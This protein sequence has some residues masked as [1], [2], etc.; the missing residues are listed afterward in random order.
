MNI[1]LTFRLGRNTLPTEAEQLHDLWRVARLLQ[2][3]GF[4]ISRWYPPAD[5]PEHSLLNPA[6]DDNGPTPAAVAIL[7]AEMQALQTPWR[8]DTAV[9]NGTEGPGGVVCV[10]AL[11]V[12]PYLPNCTL[13]LNAKRV[14]ALQD[15]RNVVTVVQGLLQIWQARTLEVAP[16]RYQ[17]RMKVFPDRP[18]AGWMLYVPTVLTVQQV[19]EAA[20]LLPVMGQPRKQAGTLIISVADAP[21]SADNPDHVRIA[22]RIEVRLVD[23]DLLPRYADQ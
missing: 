15:T 19:P 16:I 3:L 4:P 7:K 21:F 8:R 5:T 18:G 23:Q 11:S 1:T 14:D 17:T 22:N 6:F 12:D 20:T 9:W 2:P 10:N 13:R